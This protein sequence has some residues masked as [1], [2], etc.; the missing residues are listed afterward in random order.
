VRWVFVLLL[1][2]CAVRLSDI[3]LACRYLP[4]DQAHSIQFHK[5]QWGEEYLAHYYNFDGDEHFDLV[6]LFKIT[7]YDMDAKQI[8][9]TQY[10]T[11]FVYIED[12]KEYARQFDEDGDGEIES[13]TG[14]LEKLNEALD[15]F[16]KAR[17]K[18][19]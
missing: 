5:N 4:V 15:E 6:L 14:D 16:Y 3:E 7:G 11:D 1:F 13:V 12:E 9:T 8:I 2:G 10:P 18:G 19:H 17:Q